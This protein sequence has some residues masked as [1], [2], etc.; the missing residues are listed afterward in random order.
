MSDITINIDLPNDPTDRRK[1]LSKLIDALGQE[2]TVCNIQKY[3]DKYRLGFE[4]KW[5]HDE[6][7]WYFN[8]DTSRFYPS[9]NTFK[10]ADEILYG[11]KSVTPEVRTKFRDADQIS[12]LTACEEIID[13]KDWH[14]DRIAQRLVAG[15]LL[16]LWERAFMQ[17]RTDDLEIVI[18]RDPDYKPVF[19]PALQLWQII[20]SKIKD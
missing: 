14:S 6:D 5:G 18:N 9:P 8:P 4:G 1:M 7:Y 17:V 13:E 2:N 3:I 11:G 15:V 19:E 16:A 10:L 20:H 12:L